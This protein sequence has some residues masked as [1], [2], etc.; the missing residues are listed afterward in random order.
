MN[1]VKPK[2][3]PIS[4][5]IGSLYQTIPNQNEVFVNLNSTLPDRS[6]FWK[7]NQNSKELFPYGDYCL[8]LHKIFLGFLYKA[9]RLDYIV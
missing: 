5:D 9:F 8:T 3:N 2:K 4:E 1:K 7:K 6:E